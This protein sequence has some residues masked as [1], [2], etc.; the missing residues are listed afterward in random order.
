MN[1]Q[2]GSTGGANAQISLQEGSELFYYKTRFQLYLNPWIFVGIVFP[3][4]VE[5]E[6]AVGC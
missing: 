1:G 3:G 5:S 6:D 2:G 4:V